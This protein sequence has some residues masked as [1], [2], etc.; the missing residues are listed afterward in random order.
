[1]TQQ[2]TIDFTPHPCAECGGTFPA[3]ALN[4]FSL[5]EDCI[6][7]LEARADF[8]DEMTLLRDGKTP[9]EKAQEVLDTHERAKKTYFIQSD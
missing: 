9:A 7:D 8:R 4:H 1:M 6:S 5:C 2:L 3:D